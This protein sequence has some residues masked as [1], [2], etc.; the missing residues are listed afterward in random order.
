MKTPLL[1]YSQLREMWH[2]EDRQKEK[3]PYF[4]S[5]V[6]DQFYAYCVFDKVLYRYNVYG[7]EDIISMCDGLAETGPHDQ[8][9]FNNQGVLHNLKNEDLFDCSD[10]V[11]NGKYAF[12]IRNFM[13]RQMIVKVDL[14]SEREIGKTQLINNISFLRNHQK[15]ILAYSNNDIVIFDENLDVIHEIESP[16]LIDIQSLDDSIVIVSGSFNEERITLYKNQKFEW[17][18]E[19]KQPPESFLI[20]EDSLFYSTSSELLCLNW[21]GTQ[22][23]K[24]KP[25]RSLMCFIDETEHVLSGCGNEIVIYEAETGILVWK[26]NIAYPVCGKPIVY[27]DGFLIY[28]YNGGGLHYFGKENAWD[29]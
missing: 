18:C 3:L 24:N 9:F 22:R 17:S 26:T 29:F 13:D 14:M 21:D 19:I 28:S 5:P 12:L 23:W 27:R 6:L 8:L 7:E 2:V 4:P 16:L 11:I 10:F 20:T 15:G 25:A 1:T